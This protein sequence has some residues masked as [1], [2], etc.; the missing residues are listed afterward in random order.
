MIKRKPCVDVYGEILKVGDI[1]MPVCGMAPFINSVGRITKI[2]YS[3]ECQ[4]YFIAV[5]SEKSNGILSVGNSR[6]YT[7]KERYI[8]REKEPFTYFLSFSDN[9]FY[10]TNYLPLTNNTDSKYLSR[11]DTVIVEL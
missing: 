6:S 4:D 2:Y 7:T 9:N 1:V 3:E 8:E 10:Y 11:D 5:V